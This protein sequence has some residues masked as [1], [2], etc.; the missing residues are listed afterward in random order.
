MSI[1][2]PD[3]TTEHYLSKPVARITAVKV[4]GRDLKPGE[5]FSTVGPQYWDVAM[6]RGS[7]GERVYIRTNTP[8][9]LYDDL[10]EVVFRITIEVN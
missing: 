5:L 9:E 3:G 8:A 4:L 7:V 2:K 1:H 6:N 10:D